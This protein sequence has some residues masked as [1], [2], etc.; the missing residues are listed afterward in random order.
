MKWLGILVGKRNPI[1]GDQT[2]RGLSFVHF[3]SLLEDTTFKVGTKR[4]RLGWFRRTS[5]V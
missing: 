2:G 4:N 3:S 5:A 1:K